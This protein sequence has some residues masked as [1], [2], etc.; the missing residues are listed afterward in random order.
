MENNAATEVEVKVNGLPVSSP[1]LTVR[2][3]KQ[4]AELGLHMP[5]SVLKEILCGGY[6]TIYTSTLVWKFLE[7]I[8]GT[9]NGDYLQ[10]TGL[11]I[12]GQWYFL[13]YIDFWKSLLLLTLLLFLTKL[14]VLVPSKSH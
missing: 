7:K 4:V 6:M 2:G 5:I 3:E 14:P 10:R 12:W 9:V 11:G 8:L 1:S 13:F